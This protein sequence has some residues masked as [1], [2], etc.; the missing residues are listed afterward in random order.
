L[1]VAARE[2]FRASVLSRH[3]EVDLDDTGTVADVLHRWC[4]AD[5]RLGPCRECADD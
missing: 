4:R 3:A 5:L 2:R 1:D